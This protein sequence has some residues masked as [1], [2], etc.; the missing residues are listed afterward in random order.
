MNATRR[1]RAWELVAGRRRPAAALAARRQPPAAARRP[2]RGHLQGRDQLRRGR[3]RGLRP[4]GPVR[5]GPEAGG[6]RGPRGRRRAGRHRVHAGEHPDRA[7]RAGA[8][9]GHDGHRA[10]RRDQRPAVRRARLRD[11]PRRQAHGGAAQRRRSRRPP[12]QFITSYMADNDLAAV[13]TTSGQG[14]G[15]AGVHQQQAA[16]AARG[17]QLHRPEDPVGDRGA[18]RRIPASAG[19]ARGAEQQHHEGRRP[20]RHGA[21]LRRAHGARDARAASPTG[22]AASAAAARP[23]SSSARASTTTSTTSTSARRRRSSEKMRTSSPSATRSNVSIYSI[24]PRGLT[25]LADE[26]IEVSGGFPDDPTAESRACSR[27][28]TRCACRRTACAACRRRPAA[29]PR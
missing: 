19:R 16:A 24:D 8:A 22:S 26:S 3:R 27:S 1:F 13:I 12:T 4:A 9:A 7:R 17:E 20:A 21:R 29:S 23:S 11:H 10:R 14:S 28:T 6:L 15:D 18:P 5:P 2:S 25:S